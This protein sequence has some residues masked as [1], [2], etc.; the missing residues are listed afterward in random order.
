[1]A[2]LIGFI[3]R[4]ENSLLSRSFGRMG[5]ESLHVL[6]VVAAMGKTKH[7]WTFEYPGNVAGEPRKEYERRKHRVKL[8]LLL[9]FQ[10]TSHFGALQILSC[11]TATMLPVY[12]NRRKIA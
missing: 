12:R 9:L 1:M 3:I 8:M 6:S 2:G 10:T 11:S 7:G 4:W 5:R